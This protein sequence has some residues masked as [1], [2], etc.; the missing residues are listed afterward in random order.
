MR[1]TFLHFPEAAKTFD[2]FGERKMSV[3]L[4]YPT[5]RRD[6]ILL[7]EKSER[8]VAMTLMINMAQSDLTSTSLVKTIQ[9]IGNK[10][11]IKMVF[12]KAN[13]PFFLSCSHKNNGSRR[14]TKYQKTQVL[15]IAA[16]V[17]IQLVYNKIV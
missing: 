8:L 3:L 16:I 1:E 6:A 15:K 2:T 4:Y 7:I 12:C 14:M 13:I 10:L 9:I 5:L 17:R 11:T